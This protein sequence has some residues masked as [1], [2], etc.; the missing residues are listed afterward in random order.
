MGFD[1]GCCCGTV[2]LKENV[3]KVVDLPA[4]TLLRYS[5]D[6]VLCIL[7]GSARSVSF[8]LLRLTE[9]SPRAA[10]ASSYARFKPSLSCPSAGRGA[11]TGADDFT[12]ASTGAL[13][14][15]G[16]ESSPS[17]ERP[18]LSSSSR[19]LFTPL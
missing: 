7:A 19:S 5:C 11:G 16:E 6:I 10:S 13:G 9:I 17:R 15:A 14:A 8:S 18:T 4:F 3:V 1:G 12:V 2:E